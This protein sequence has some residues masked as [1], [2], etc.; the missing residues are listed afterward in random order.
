MTDAPPA[1]AKARATFPVRLLATIAGAACAVAVVLVPMNNE[2]FAAAIAAFWAALGLG[3]LDWALFGRSA[4]ARWIRVG[5]AVV[6]G[7]AIGNWFRLDADYAFNV[8][9]GAARPTEI[10]NLHIRGWFYGRQSDQSIRLF[11]NAE[12]PTLDTLLARRFQRVSEREAELAEYSEYREWWRFFWFE[13]PADSS[14]GYL[15]P[16]TDPEIYEW[17][18]SEIEGTTLIYDPPTGRAFALYRFG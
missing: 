8:A 13:R 5:L 12:R 6:I 3:Y 18:G 17:S 11:F 1:P 15:A 9:F 10:R 4:G 14:S 7:G 2:A 16:L